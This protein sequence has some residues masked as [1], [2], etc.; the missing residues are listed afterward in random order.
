MYIT[1]NGGDS[2]E[3]IPL[4]F[5]LGGDLIFHPSAQRADYVLANDTVTGVRYKY[6]LSEC[7][8]SFALS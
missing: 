3:K 2:F 5:T 4:P 8:V 1:E 6:C 7:E